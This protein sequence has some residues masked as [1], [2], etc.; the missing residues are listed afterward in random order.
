MLNHCSFKSYLNSAEKKTFN[1]KGK[2]EPNQQFFG[3]LR[4]R[5]WPNS[6]TPFQLKW[7]GKE[8]ISILCAF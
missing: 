4:N 5:T 7:A 8:A 1:R 2:S 6:Y 3:K